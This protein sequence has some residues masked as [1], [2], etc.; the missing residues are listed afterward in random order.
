[1]PLVAPRVIAV[2]GASTSGNA[3][4]N[5]FLRQLE[6]A[7]FDG[8]VVV[9]HPSATSV[10]GYAA[11][12]SL[13]DVP[14]TVDYAYVAVPSRSVPALIASGAGRVR[15]AQVISSGFGE[16]DGVG[17]DLANE[18]LRVARETGTRIVG[19]NSLG[20]HSPRGGMSFV[21]G[22]SAPDGT[23]SV[24]SQSGGLSVDMIRRGRSLG[25]DF[26]SVVSVGNAL[27]V[28]PIELA[29]YYLADPGTTAIGLYL[30]Y[31]PDGRRFVDLL[32]RSAGTKP[33]VVLKGG[34]TA[35][36]NRA[37]ASHTGA[38]AT[39]ERLWRGLARQFG[40]TLVETMDEYLHSLLA[41]QDLARAPRANARDVVLL[42]NGGGVS[43]LAADQFA[44]ADLAVPPVSDELLRA[45]ETIPFPPGASVLN[46]IDLPAGVFASEGGALCE[47]LLRLVL[48]RDAPG[49]IVVHLNLG[50]ML[51]GP[52]YLAGF[53]GFLTAALPMLREHRDQSLPVLVLNSD[54]SAEADELRRSLTSE[55]REWRIPV[56]TGFAGAIRIL[57][58]LYEHESRMLHTEAT[59]S[60]G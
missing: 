32:R 16:G 18:L 56:V 25:L 23:I 30:E 49:G 37:A 22:A 24:A 34:L 31:L 35:Q 39:D 6:E 10:D 46:P 4:G 38:A 54:G 27:D 50:A 2:A 33:I 47:S 1:M 41:F 20:T 3:Q 9:I 12:P 17:V 59:T 60:V 19:P 55:A 28:D 51:Q 36:G 14:E 40:I 21:G 5:T 26:R 44:R 11:V 48:E 58:T 13:A 52:V 43:V 8:T 57:S 15:F 42:G 53:R 45:A 7:G 29:E